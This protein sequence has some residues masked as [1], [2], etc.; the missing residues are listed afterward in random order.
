MTI[1]NIGI[2]KETASFLLK[3]ILNKKKKKIVINIFIIPITKIFDG[4]VKKAKSTIKP[5]NKHKNISFLP[6]FSL[7][8]IIDFN[9][10]G[11]LWQ[12]RKQLNQSSRLNQ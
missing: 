11:K 10:N 4:G 8:S 6:Y 9:Y 2:V 3:K 5:I 1:K 7:A 12:K